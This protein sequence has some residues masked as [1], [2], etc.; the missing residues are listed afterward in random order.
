[1]KGTARRITAAAALAML[2]L[3]APAA[4]AP[5]LYD[6]DPLR[7]GHVQVASGV[8][9]ADAG[10]VIA[11]TVDRRAALLRLRHDGTVVE[12]FG[13]GGV[14][15]VG[16]RGETAVAVTAGPGGRRIVVAVRDRSG[17]TQLLGVD[18][19][20]RPRRG[21][22]P[23]PLT[24]SG[25]VALAA[26]GSRVAVA[27]AAGVAVLDARTGGAVGEGAG[28]PTPRSAVL[29]GAGRLLV[30]CGPSIAVY[31]AGTAQ[32]AGSAPAGGTPALVLG[33]A[34]AADVCVAEQVGDGVR[35]RRADPATLLTGDPFAGAPALPAPDRLTGLAPDPR[36]GCNL[37]LAKPGASRVLQ[38][39]ESGRETKLTALPA[40]LHP[41]LLFVCH[42][43]VLTAGVRHEHGRAVAALAIVKRDDDG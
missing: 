24:G 14:A 33:L 35:T 43:H 15:R 37:L 18:G 1:V 36:G 8:R 42:S 39:D 9:L 3:C 27:T 7:G 38:T 29:A 12:S 40:A 32:P 28:C 10:A 16:A 21:F 30:A 13:R 34:D 4:A 19:R 22:G 6:L 17:A 2:A 11:A 23:V 31:H 20:G 25:P 41:K 5:R 26:R